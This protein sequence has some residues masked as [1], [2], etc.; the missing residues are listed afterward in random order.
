MSYMVVT[1]SKRDD[2]PLEGVS[3]VA[4]REKEQVA[5]AVVVQEGSGNRAT[6]V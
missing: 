3:E 4:E 6:A 5:Y 2:A 1:V